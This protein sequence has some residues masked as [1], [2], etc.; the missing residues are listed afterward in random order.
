MQA[1]Y[2]IKEGE[3]SFPI[4]VKPTGKFDDRAHFISNKENEFVQV[5]RFCAYGWG[6]G[7]G[8][9]TTADLS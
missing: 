5:S 2:H 9:I 6:R 1:Y 7:W 8:P 3:H 4:Y